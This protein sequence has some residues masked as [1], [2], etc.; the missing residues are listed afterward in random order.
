[1]SDRSGTE[2][3]A[4]YVNLLELEGMARRVL[5]RDIFDFYAGGRRTN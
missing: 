2:S 4:R 1:M 3:I 5:P